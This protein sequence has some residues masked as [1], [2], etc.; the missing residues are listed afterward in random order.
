MSQNDPKSHN[1]SCPSC[2]YCQ[3]CGRGGRQAYPFYPS[4]P[5]WWT[6]PDYYPH[7]QVY[8]SPW[9]VTSGSTATGIVPFV[10]GMTVHYEGNPYVNPNASW[11]QG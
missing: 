3:H 6:Q 5:P 11:T 4:S 10:T 9:Q 7:W 2:G 1:G 8:P